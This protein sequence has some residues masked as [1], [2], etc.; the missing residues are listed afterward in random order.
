MGQQSNQTQILRRESFPLFSC[1]RT[2]R[3]GKPQ[4]VGAQTVEF[5]DLA[6]LKRHSRHTQLQEHKFPFG[7]S[8]FVNVESRIGMP[9]NFAFL[10]LLSNLQIIT[11]E[12]LPM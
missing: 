10:P 9:Q 6:Q 11:G 4:A 12:S 1:A 8:V 3:I 7:C 5:G 2:R